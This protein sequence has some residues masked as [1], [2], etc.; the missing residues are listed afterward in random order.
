MLLLMLDFAEHHERATEHSYVRAKAVQIRSEAICQ[1]HLHRDA[2]SSGQCPLIFPAAC[3]SVAARSVI[4]LMHTQATSDIPRRLPPKSTTPS[5][6]L[7]LATS[8]CAHTHMGVL[9]DVFVSRSFGV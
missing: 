1:G 3:R 2:L 7:P 5:M 4:S 8:V 9:V 6:P